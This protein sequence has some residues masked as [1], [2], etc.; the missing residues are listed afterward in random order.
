MSKLRPREV[1]R[2]TQP[3]IA[4]LVGLEFYL[5]TRSLPFFPSTCPHPSCHDCLAVKVCL[6]APSSGSGSRLR[7]PLWCRPGFLNLKWTMQQNHLQGCWKQIAGLI[8]GVSDSV[9]LGQGPIICISN[10]IQGDADLLIQRPLIENLWCRQ[11]SCG[12]CRQNT[13]IQVPALLCMY[14]NLEHNVT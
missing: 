8:L 11:R 3:I 2:I 14:W 6:G 10:K 5:L 1:L 12:S 7:A 4:E 9:G 13:G